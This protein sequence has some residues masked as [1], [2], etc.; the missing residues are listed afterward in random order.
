[1]GVHRTW[2]WPN[3]PDSTATY[4]LLNG[5]SQAPPPPRRPSLAN[6][7]PNTK[8]PVDYEVPTAQS[9]GGRFPAAPDSMGDQPGAL[10]GT[11]SARRFSSSAR[12]AAA[13]KAGAGGGFGKF[14]STRPVTKKAS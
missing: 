11:Q 13:D 2:G 7:A 1:M 8:A 5:T 9:Q 12:P 4:R 6:A 10:R 3:K 14:K